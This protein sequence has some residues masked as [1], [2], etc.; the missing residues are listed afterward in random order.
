[1]IF[2]TVGNHNEG[3]DRLI[4]KIDEIAI[5]L[6]EKVVMQ[7][8]TATYEPKNAEYFKFCSSREV[9]SLVKEARVVVSHAGA[10][11]IINA[12]KYGKPI[13]IVPRRKK[14]GEV[15]D[16]HQL[17][18]ASAMS[19]DRRIKAVYQVEDLPEALNNVTAV[20]STAGMDISCIRL[21]A[22]LRQYLEEIDSS[23]K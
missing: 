22:A 1:M 9:E 12:L 7:T 20:A 14:Y 13:I 3:F 8:G 4:Q 21:V 23:R 19:G 16:D 5:D 2:V 10:A 17:E 18:L 6:D 11:S 15:V